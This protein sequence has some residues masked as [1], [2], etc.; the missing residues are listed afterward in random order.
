MDQAS[1]VELFRKSF[2]SWNVQL[3]GKFTGDPI[4]VNERECKDFV[5]E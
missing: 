5:I 2:D 4:E 1:A 3:G